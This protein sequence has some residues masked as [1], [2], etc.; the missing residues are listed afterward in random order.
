MDL[1]PF[2]IQKPSKWSNYLPNLQPMT[3]YMQKYLCDWYFIRLL[4]AKRSRGTEGA[5]AA[6]QAN[7]RVTYWVWRQRGELTQPGPTITHTKL[8]YR[9][10]RSTFLYETFRKVRYKYRFLFFTKLNPL[11][12]KLVFLIYLLKYWTFF[13]QFAAKDAH[14]VVESIAALLNRFWIIFST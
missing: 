14:L 4:R 13:N 9:A 8:L 7:A 3:A 1:L 5:S 11:K 10:N 2:S 12:K 6:E